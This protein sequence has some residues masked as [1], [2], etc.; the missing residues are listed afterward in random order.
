MFPRGSEKTT[1]DSEVTAAGGAAF[2]AAEVPPA[3]RTP[4]RPTP[5]G[6][7]PLYPPTPSGRLRRPPSAKATDKASAKAAATEKMLLLSAWRLRI[8][9]PKSSQSV[10]NLAAGRR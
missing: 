9:N 2:P 1:A 10:R 3:S 5:R 4:G 8:L 6:I 7:G